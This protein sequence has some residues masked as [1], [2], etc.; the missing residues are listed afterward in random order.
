MGGLCSSSL[1]LTTTTTI[2]T[3]TTTTTTP[4]HQIVRH[5][6]VMYLVDSP[7]TCSS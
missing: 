1:A 3:T 5:I 2:T 7:L 6:L 4:Y